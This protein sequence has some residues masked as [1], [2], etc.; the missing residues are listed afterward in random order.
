MEIIL[1]K[2]LNENLGRSS[3]IW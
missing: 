1:Q 3:V 2:G